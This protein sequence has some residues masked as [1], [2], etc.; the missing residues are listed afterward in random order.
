MSVWVAASAHSLGHLRG[1]TQL[2]RP[3]YPPPPPNF[4]CGNYFH[5]SVSLVFTGGVTKGRWQ[6]KELAVFVIYGMNLLILKWTNSNPKVGVDKV[7]N[8]FV[9]YWLYINITLHSCESCEPKLSSEADLNHADASKC[10]QL[11]L[12]SDNVAL[13]TSES[14]ASVAGKQLQHWRRTGH[15]TP[16]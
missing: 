2:L 12:L 9:M 3:W 13:L 5:S 6:L 11:S 10:P 1:F 14:F 8:P 4:P 16:V 15:L 7:C